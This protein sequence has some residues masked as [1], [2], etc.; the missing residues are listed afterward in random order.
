MNFHDNKLW[1]DAYV[2]LM[3]IYT[4]LDEVDP[5][6][7]EQE[8]ETIESLLTASQ[9][10]AAK[11]SDGLSRNDKRVGKDLLYSAIGLVAIV[12][13]HIAIAWGRGIIDD[14]KL[15]TLDDKY[16]VLSQNLQAIR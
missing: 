1:Q 11:I 16:Q 12:R 4:T 5:E 7:R 9:N 6:V 8:E 15:K 13:T 3:D 2:V 14:E 10:V